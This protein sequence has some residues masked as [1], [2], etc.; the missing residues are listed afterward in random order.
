MHCSVVS[1]S[2]GGQSG[3]FV[4]GPDARRLDV[5]DDVESPDSTRHIG[6]DEIFGDLIEL[7][8]D[9]IFCTCGPLYCVPS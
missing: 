2:T 3:E 8:V 1:C 4:E 7:I 9:V 5:A 6:I